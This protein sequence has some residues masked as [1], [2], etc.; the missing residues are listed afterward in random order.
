MKH[1]N[2]FSL[3]ALLTITLMA[4]N[5]YAG[6]AIL[7]ISLM[8]ILLLSRTVAIIMQAKEEPPMRLV[9]VVPSP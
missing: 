6:A 2:I 5:V 3:F 8:G 1:S 9:T 7:A 4:T